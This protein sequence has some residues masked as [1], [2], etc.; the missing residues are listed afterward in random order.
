MKLHCPTCN[1]PVDIGNA[2]RYEVFTCACGRQFR[3]LHAEECLLD[4]LFWK[5]AGPT[6]RLF[7]FGLA[8][9]IDQNKLNYT[10]C[11]YCDAEISISYSKE[12]LGV[13]GPVNCWACTRTLPTDAVNNLKKWVTIDGERRYVDRDYPEPTAR[14]TPLP[15]PDP[16]QTAIPAAV[17]PP[18]AP[19]PPKP[20]KKHPI[21]RPFTMKEIAKYLTGS[22]DR[23]NWAN[24]IERLHLTGPEIRQLHSILSFTHEEITTLR[25]KKLIGDDE[26]F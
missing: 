3:G 2:S 25:K 15:Q 10:F 12:F 7:S 21:V 20:S 23:R 5:F 17:D 16:P 26:R 13:T 6:M 11:P 22:V 19:K 14:E 18:S 24:W 4:Y 9:R 1:Q 8:G